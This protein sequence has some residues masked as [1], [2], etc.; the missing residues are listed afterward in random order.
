MEEAEVFATFEGLGSVQ[1]EECIETYDDV[2]EEDPEED[3]FGYE[4]WYG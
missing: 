4:H 1:D 3:L 2:A